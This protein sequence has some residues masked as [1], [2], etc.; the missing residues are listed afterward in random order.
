MKNHLLIGCAF[1]INLQLLA[2][3]D[4]GGVT[5]VNPLKNSS[6]SP[7]T[8]AF[9]IKDPYRTIDGRNFVVPGIDPQNG[10]VSFQGTIVE[11]QPSGV[12]INGSYTGYGMGGIGAGFGDAEYFVANFPYSVAENELI[13]TQ[14]GELF[15]ARTAGTYSYTTVLG[16][17]KTL[18]KLDYG[19][20]YVPPPPTPEQIAAAQK[21]AAAAKLKVASAK[22][23]AAESALAMNRAAAEKGDAYGLLRMGERYRDGD[24]VEKNLSEARH[25]LTRAVAAG[26]PSAQA[27]LDKLG[28]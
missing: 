19:K 18:R 26:S 2:G 24:G 7:G 17:T 23:A 13:G 22:K 11:V 4:K 28:K 3:P 15:I 5:A 20:I 12:R 14:P 16:G 25:Y 21:A 1:L 27:E 9:I 10:W 6:E 8:P